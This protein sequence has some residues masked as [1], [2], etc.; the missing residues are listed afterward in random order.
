MLFLYTDAES[1]GHVAAVAIRGAEIQYMDF[2]IPKDL[3][4]K[5]HFRR[6]QIVAFE[7]IAGVIG[8]EHFCRT[9]GE[10]EGIVHYVDSQPALNILMKGFSRQ[11]DLCD[12]VG[13][14]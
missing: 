13:S 12:I 4:S 14:L 10:S 7:L 11:S 9:L 2:D 6:T 5:L 8:I 1:S 3:I